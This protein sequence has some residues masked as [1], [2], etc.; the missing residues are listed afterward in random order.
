M[1]VAVTGA[2]GFVGGV[3]VG[4][5]LAA[6]HDV[7]ALSRRPVPERP[8]L[9]HRPWDLTTGRLPGPPTVD[10]VVHA[11]AHVDEWSPW[12]VHDAVTVRGTRAVLDTWPTARVVLVSSASVYPLRGRHRPRWVLTEADPPTRRPLSAY[13][14]AKIAQEQLVLAR[15][16]TLVLRPHA[17]HGPGDT[18]L[19]PRLARARRRGRL[20]C[21]GG[22]APGCTSPTCASW[23]LPPSG[24]ARSTAAQTFSMWPTTDHSSCETSLRASSRPTAGRSDRSSPGRPDVGRRA[25]PRGHRTPAEVAHPTLLTA[26]GVSHLAVTLA[27]STT[28]LRER[29]GLDPS[30]HRPDPLDRA[31]ATH[32]SVLTRPQVAHSRRQNRGTMSAA[33]L[34]EASDLPSTLPAVAHPAP[35]PC[36]RPAVVA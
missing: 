28:P 18:T 1:R 14:R 24:R 6:G 10:A 23:Q 26:Y 15:S 32:T 25:R 19:L 4:H 29:L 34:P 9:E 8:G 11:A 3:V 33:V 5:L 35:R 2:S 17:V 13:S 31:G 7:V 22:P 12:S 16:G 27:F 20:V 30:A 21:P 36:A